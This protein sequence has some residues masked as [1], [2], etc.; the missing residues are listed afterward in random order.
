VFE[1]FTEKK[2]ICR[3]IEKIADTLALKIKEN[4]KIKIEFHVLIYTLSSNK[5]KNKIS[6]IFQK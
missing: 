2:I 6:C 3:I 1:K 5:I 4:L